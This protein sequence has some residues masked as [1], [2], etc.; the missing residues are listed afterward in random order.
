[1]YYSL[2]SKQGVSSIISIAG[3]FTESISERQNRIIKNQKLCQLASMSPVYYFRFF[4]KE[5]YK[6][7]YRFTLIIEDYS[8]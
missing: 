7:I 2:F 1:M 8:K 4:N 5:C 3:F 6:K